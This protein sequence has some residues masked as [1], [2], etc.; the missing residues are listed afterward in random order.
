MYDLVIMLTFISLLFRR[1]GL[2][3]VPH[4]GRDA[5]AVGNGGRCIFLQFLFRPYIFQKS[6]KKIKKSLFVVVHFEC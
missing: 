3:I 1:Q 4:D 6:K 5:T 2:N